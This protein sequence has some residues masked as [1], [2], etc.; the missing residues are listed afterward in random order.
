MSC[1]LM[2]KQKKKKYIYIYENNLL[3]QRYG[4]GISRSP[5]F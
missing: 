2:L 4:H 3:A 1:I 5:R